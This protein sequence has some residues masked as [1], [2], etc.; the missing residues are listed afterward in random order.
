MSPHS[1]L[2]SLHLALL[3]VCV[4]TACDSKKINKKSTYEASK[5]SLDARDIH[6]GPIRHADLSKDLD[7]RIRK[8][9]T[10]FSEVYPITHKEWLEGFQRDTVPENEVAIWEHI[11]SAYSKFL[12]SN[13][14]GA[15]A[16]KEAFGLLLV[17]SGTSDVESQFSKLKVLTPDQAKSLIAQYEAEPKPVTYRTLNKARHPTGHKPPKFFSPTS[18]TAHGKND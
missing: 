14:V 3:F 4:L 12:E 16:R 8:F 18:S 15:A 7:A 11:A 5:K 9:E 10:V 17:R 2:V 6:P 13:G 1:K